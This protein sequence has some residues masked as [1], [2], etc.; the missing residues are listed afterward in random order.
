MIDWKRYLESV[1]ED[2]E[3]TEWEAKF[4]PMDAKG[5]VPGTHLDLMV[6]AFQQ[7][8]NS[9]EVKTHQKYY[10]LKGLRDFAGEHVLLRGRPG[11]GKTTIL[12]HL[13]LEE[14]KKAKGDGQ[15]R[16]PIFVALR[17][18]KNPS[19]F[20]SPPV[21]VVRD[22]LQ[23]HHVQVAVEQLDSLLNQ[24]RFFLIFDGMNEM[25]EEDSRGDLESFRLKYRATTP[26]VFATR[27]LGFGGDLGIRK[28]L[29]ILPLNRKQIEIFVHK[30]IGDANEA[31]RML[32]SLKDRLR[33]LA[34]TPLL[35]WMLCRVFEAKQKMPD[36]LGEVFRIFTRIYE[37]GV[38]AGAPVSEESRSWWPKLLAK[39]AHHMMEKRKEP[40]EMALAIHCEEAEYV[41]REYLQEQGVDRPVQKAPR[42]LDDLVKHHLLTENTRGNIEFLHH[43]IQ[44]YYAAEH[45]LS[46]LPGLAETKPQ[47]LKRDYLNYLK[48]TEPV[49]MM[50]EF[51]DKED[52]AM[53]CVRL[54]LDVDLML[55]ARLAGCLK[56]EFQEKGI[57]LV[58]K[59]HGSSGLGIRLLVGKHYRVSDWLKHW[60]KDWRVLSKAAKAV[61]N[62]GRED[63][64]QELV[65]ASEDDDP[66]VRIDVAEALASIGSHKAVQYLI[67]AL[68]DDDSA[69][70]SGAAFALGNIGSDEAVQP[71]TIALQDDDSAVRSCAVYALGEIG[72]DEAI[73][74]LAM[75]LQDEIWVLRRA[76][77]QALGNIGSQDAIQHLTPALKD[78][79]S[80]VRISA[81]TALADLGSDD[82]TQY[83]MNLLE[84]ED[85]LIRGEAVEVLER[86]PNEKAL[87][88]LIRAL[89]HEDWTIRQMAAAALGKIG[90]D[91]GTQ[92]LINALKDDVSSVR[93]NAAW[94]LGLIGS[95]L[96]I[97]PLMNALEDKDGTVRSSAASALGFIG[98]DKAT[99]N[100]VDLLEDEEGRVRGSAAW[101]L[102]DIK[103]GMA[104]Q[105]LIDVLKVDDP[106]A[107]DNAAKALAKIGGN[108]ATDFLIEAIESGT[109]FSAILHESSGLSLASKSLPR[110]AKLAQQRDPDLLEVIAAIQERCRFYNPALLTIDRRFSIVHLSDLHF[111]EVDRAGDLYVGLLLELKEDLDLKIFEALV[112]SGDIVNQCRK[113]GY[114]HA[115]KFLSR[116]AKKFDLGPDRVVVVPGN[117]DMSR[118]LS[119]DAYTLK[120]RK[121]VAGPIDEFLHIDRGEVVEVKHEAKYKKRFALFQ[122]FCKKAAI[123]D[124]R[125]DYSNQITWREYPDQKVLMVGLN[126]SWMLDHHYKRRSGLHPD[127]LN[128]AVER[129]VK[130]EY[131]DWLKIAVWHHPVKSRSAEETQLNKSFMRDDGFMER[132]AVAGFSMI[133]HG[134]AHDGNAWP[135]SFDSGKRKY[136]VHVI[137]AGTLDA[138]EDELTP[139]SFWQYNIIQVTGTKVR[140]ECRQRVNPRGISRPDKTWLEDAPDKSTYEF[141]LFDE[142]T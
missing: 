126:S 111:K 1:C 69:V 119:E 46:F 38:K 14:A 82:A 67:R 124:Y 125:A 37:R 130:D 19:R 122:A 135:F 32:R 61:V 129:A 10:A 21:Y 92:H 127:A 109:I 66:G 42:F 85:W 68:E 39:L 25:P 100:L 120:R 64:I 140:V 88:D 105:A 3:Y 73:Q 57:A 98:S 81:A 27:D 60:A 83:L 8:E 87:S 44:E 132:L 47:R 71:L 108:E 18:W 20:E 104:T 70:R 11:S 35:L 93:S 94:A 107:R 15:A 62:F 115:T 23:R 28:R 106:F 2:P 96:A 48:W 54:A 138:D 12:H 55:G 117:H 131:K 24:G 86:I 95:D 116:I 99:Q 40:T 45:L 112:I 89:Q 5:P 137:G 9:G 142:P 91:H 110:L 17:R 101:A 51:C 72:S 84:D 7:S 43:L 113:E 121:E 123:G 74:P 90:N 78:E 16:I 29:E 75:V 114:D 31:R 76:A 97:E 139:G 65:M 56:R 77:V 102:G 13:L 80:M 133:L 30:Y 26:M 136:T 59:M 36:R 41:L 134:H 50:L 118:Q 6:Q 63:A 53:A 33:N 103:S 34:K 4:T 22:T 141:D 52:Q 79:D 49:A 58:T 128:Q